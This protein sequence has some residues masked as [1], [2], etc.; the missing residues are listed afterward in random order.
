MTLSK[1]APGPIR[2]VAFDLDGTLTRA[3]TCCE[4]IARPLGRLARMREFEPPGTIEEI[5]AAR[6]EMAGWYAGRRR[7]ELCAPLADVALAPGARAGF[8]R[9]RRHG[10]ATALVSITWDFAVAWFARALGADYH[11]GTGLA[12]GG[13][14]AHFWPEDKA[15]WVRS[16]AGELGVGLHQVA[17]VG[18]SPGDL[19]LLRIVGLPFFVGR[20]LPTGFEHVAHHPDGDIDRIARIIV[21]TGC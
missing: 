16:L 6:A 13:E 20:T 19:P 9:L 2:L 10:I 15:R 4:A 7:A 5:A 1:R 11:V 3:E 8:A 14:I 17:A 21:G 12:A 18:D